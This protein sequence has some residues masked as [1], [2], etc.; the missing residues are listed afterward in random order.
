M[1]GAMILGATLG[2]RLGRLGNEYRER[3]FGGSEITA[4]IALGNRAAVL[5]AN[6]MRG[7]TPTSSLGSLALGIFGR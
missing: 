2:P 4:D 7:A 6:V 3:L 1:V 5:G